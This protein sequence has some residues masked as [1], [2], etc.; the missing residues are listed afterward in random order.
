MLALVLLALC[1]DIIIRLVIAARQRDKMIRDVLD[2]MTE[3]E[4]VTSIQTPAGASING[5]GIHLLRY[6]QQST[7][8]RDV[9][10][11]L[12]EAPEVMTERAHV[13]AV[14]H[15]RRERKKGELPS[16]A[17]LNGARILRGARLAE[18]LGSGVQVTDAG[19]QLN[20]AIQQPFRPALNRD[21]VVS[22]A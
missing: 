22:P 5:L 12:A 11:V 14:D 16:A 1:I 2:T 8:S 13:N 18:H 9:L 17:I 7:A 15:L 20:E 6:F 19:R 10:S 3:P 21:F 4:S